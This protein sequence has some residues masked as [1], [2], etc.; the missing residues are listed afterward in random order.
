MAR[1]PARPSPERSRRS[2]SVFEAGKPALVF[3]SN[4]EVSPDSIDPEQLQRLRTYRQQLRNAG[5]TYDY[6]SQ[7]DLF[8][9]AFQALARVMRDRFGN[10]LGPRSLALVAGTTAPSRTPVGPLASPLARMTT[11]R[12]LTG[13]SNRGQPRYIS[14]SRLLVEKRG[15]L[16]AENLAVT[17]EAEGDRPAPS[18]VG[19]DGPIR[20]LPPGGSVEYPIS[21]T[22]G[23]SPQW[24]IVFSWEESGQTYTRRQSMR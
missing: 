12:E 4:E 11:D 19:L 23:S 20:R 10:E 3:F 16:D 5:L 2:S 7:D 14:R 9:R 8:R 1:Q 22:M 21:L 18:I 24:D 17:T 13:F 6:G 15:T